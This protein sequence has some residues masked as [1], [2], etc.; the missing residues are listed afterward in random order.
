MWRDDL[1]GIY[2][3][4]LK[5]AEALQLVGLIRREMFR[6]TARGNGRRFLD[7]RRVCS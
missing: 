3:I 5:L 1:R 4:A 7:L 6:I 2:Y